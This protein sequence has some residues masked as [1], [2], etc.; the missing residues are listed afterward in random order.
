M[1]DTNIPVHNTHGI[2]ILGLSTIGD[3][4]NCHES[5]ACGN[6]FGSS[7]LQDCVLVAPKTHTECCFT[8]LKSTR[9]EIKKFNI[10]GE[11]ALDI[12]CG[13]IPVNLK[14]RKE[15]NA[16]E[17]AQKEEFYLHYSQQSFEIKL[18]HSASRCLDQVTVGKILA[19][20]RV[21]RI[22]FRTRLSTIN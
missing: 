2:K 14:G 3:L 21:T 6:L 4:W 16:E 8:H 9:E 7:P 1:E 13:L 22:H 20:K 19:G 10:N 5:V 11:L 17:N 12:L 15:S 18:H